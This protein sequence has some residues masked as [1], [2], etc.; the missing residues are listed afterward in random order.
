MNT[1]VIT[2]VTIVQKGSGPKLGQI[3][4]PAKKIETVNNAVLAACLTLY[5]YDSKR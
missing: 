1:K 2:N 3:N 5:P 4:T